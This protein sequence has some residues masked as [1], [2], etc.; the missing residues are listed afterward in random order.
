MAAKNK[1]EELHGALSNLPVNSDSLFDS[2]LLLEDV[3][4]DQAC[5]FLGVFPGKWKNLCGLNRHT[6]QSIKFVKEK[7]YLLRQI[8]ISS[9]KTVKDSLQ[10]LLGIAQSHLR[11]LCWRETIRKRPWKI[12][13]V[14]EA[15]LKNPHK[16]G[17]SVLYS[18]CEVRIRCEKLSL[19]NFKMQSLSDPFCDVPLSPLNGLPSA[20]VISKGFNSSCFKADFS[21]FLYSRRN[22]SSHSI[23]MISTW[24]LT[25]SIKNVL[26]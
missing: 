2:A 24:Y 13:Q 17:K 1:W 8:E 19:D 22:G 6:Q 20:P 18:K 11:G 4:Y 26:K 7:N 21:Y 23:N 5:R 25:R 14:N 9:D 12:G 15:F 16:A 10:S 3:I